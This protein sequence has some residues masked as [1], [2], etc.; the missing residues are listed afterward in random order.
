MFLTKHLPDSPMQR[1]KQS[2][3]PWFRVSRLEP[4]NIQYL[5]KVAEGRGWVRLPF[6]NEYGS[7]VYNIA[8]YHEI[9]CLVRSCKP[10]SDTAT[11]F[12]PVLPVA[13]IFRSSRKEQQQHHIHPTLR[14]SRPRISCKTLFR[15]YPQWLDLQCRHNAGALQPEFEYNCGVGC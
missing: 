14:F 13:L 12:S 10:L 4:T 9:H 6:I 1:S 5:K 2:G 3:Q 7:D 15:V 11:Y 8:V